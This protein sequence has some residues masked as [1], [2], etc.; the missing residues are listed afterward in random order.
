MKNKF[1][2]SAALLAACVTFASCN[3]EEVSN[4][5]PKESNEQNVFKARGVES[6][7]PYSDNV[8]FQTWGIHRHWSSTAQDCITPAAECFDDIVVTPYIGN[9]L[10]VIDESLLITFDVI[11]HGDQRKIVDSFTQY[12]TELSYY[13]HKEYLDKVISQ[14]VVVSFENTTNKDVKFLAF[15]DATGKL[16]AVYPFRID[17]S[18]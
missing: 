4:I 13:I 18:N 12:Y 6:T 2:F 5:A 9:D 15:K 17:E 3:S 1:L 14:E 8:G 16:E 10:R 11:N 7:T